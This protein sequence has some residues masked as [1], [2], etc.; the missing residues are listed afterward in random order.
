MDSF[1]SPPFIQ[2]FLK[3]KIGQESDLTWPGGFLGGATKVKDLQ[4]LLDLAVLVII[5]R[6]LEEGLLFVELGHD[7]AHSP[8]IDFR[9]VFGGTQQQLWRPVPERHHLL[10][11][12]AV[13][14]EL[15]REAKVSQ[16]HQT[17]FAQQDVG[18]FFWGEDLFV[19]K[20]GFKQ[21][22]KKSERR[23]TLEIAVQD[24]FLEY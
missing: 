1:T 10:G 12:L 19:Q 15:L 23:V 24:S 16:L 21:Q 3:K 9:I 6:G 4:Q 7:A 8:D 17:L 2:S 5:E 11:E 22:G 13:V 20:E 18:T 14:L